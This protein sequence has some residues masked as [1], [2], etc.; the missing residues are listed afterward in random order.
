MVKAKDVFFPLHI[1]NVDTEMLEEQRII[2]NNILDRNT[3][4]GFLSGNEE[5]ALTGVCNMLDY[6][7]DKKYYDQHGSNTGSRGLIGMK[8][9]PDR[10]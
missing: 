5:A 8:K 1:E 6:W 3:K 9:N 10:Q 2:I 4:E 7:S